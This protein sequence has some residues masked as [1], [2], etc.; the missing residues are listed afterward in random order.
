M[1]SRVHVVGAG[2]AGLSASL[3]LARKGIPISLWEM[4][5]QAGG[6]CRSYQDDILGLTIDNGNHLVLSGNTAV[7][8]YL[9]EIGTKHLLLGPTQSE[10]PFMDLA[11]GTRWILRPNKSRWPWWVLDRRRRVPGTR[12]RDYLAV[13]ALSRPHPGLRVNEVISCRGVLWDKL[14]RPLLVSALNTAPETASADLAGA[15]IRETLAKGGRY[16][17]PLVASPTLAATFID[18]AMSRLRRGGVELHFDRGLKS[19]EFENDRV[20]RLQFDNAGISVEHD[21]AVILA[22]PP[23]AVERLAPGIVVPNIFHAIVNAHFRRTPPP[24]APM[25]MGMIGTTADWVFSFQDR[26]SVTVSAADR[27]LEMDQDVLSS[28]LWRDVSV[29]L[30]INDPMPPVRI[31]KEKRATFAATPEQEARRPPS[32][33]RWKNLFLAG[34]WVNT[35]LPATIE[36]ALRSGERAASL[37]LTSTA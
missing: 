17:R 32:Q 33:T 18:P 36:G 15:V 26:I 35:G 29:A 1:K 31:L 37:A 24:Q 30:D 4:T 16:T 12:A 34:D 9:D 6:R 11:L 27:L 14:L 20:R 3:E 23:W 28:M 8:R 21:D 13:L 7:E 10:F 22:V 25:I 2:L 5:G 19:I